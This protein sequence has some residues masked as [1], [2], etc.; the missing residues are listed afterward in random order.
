MDSSADAE[1]DGVRVKER[2]NIV[3][4]MA[5]DMGYGDVGCYNRE[6]RIPTPHMDRLAAEGMR[7]TD[8]H[9]PSAVC[10]PTR[11][12]VLTG[13]YCWRTRL[14]EGVIGGY[15]RPLI[16]EGR[17]TMA[18]ILKQSGYH[19]ACIGKWHVGHRRTHG[20]GL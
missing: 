2:P 19:T 6:S 8:A 10:T 11:Y 9:A 14:K 1:V 16:E 20:R 12:G 4:I 15:S 7:F 17:P 5:D 18:S 13:R 3:I